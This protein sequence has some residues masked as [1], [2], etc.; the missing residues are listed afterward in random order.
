MRK[1]V[2]NEETL[3]THKPKFI[4][5][6]GVL[7]RLSINEEFIKYD[8]ELVQKQLVMLKKFRNLVIQ[9]VHDTELSLHPGESSTES[10]VRK[11]FYW[12]GL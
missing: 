3:S 10:L 6:Q 7:Y 5:R 9:L 1:H 12:P 11:Y 2:H 8:H 4:F